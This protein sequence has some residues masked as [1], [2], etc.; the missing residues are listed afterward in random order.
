[1]TTTPA[2]DS[3][4]TSAPRERT[5]E[6]GR[7]VFHRS[8]SFG[9]VQGIEIGANWSWFLVFGLIVWSLAAAV[10]PDARPGLG[11][12][13]YVA[14][15]GVGAV[16]FFTSLVLHEL[17]H[18]VVAKREG[19]EIAGITLW[20]FGGVA[21]FKG[22]FPSAWAE[23][24]IA[25]AGPLVSVAI[26]LSCLA[27]GEYAGLPAEADAVVDWLGAINLVLVAFNMLPALPLDGGRVLRSLL[28]EAMGDFTRATRYAGALGRAFGQAMIFGG[29]V[30]LL[31]GGAAGGLWLALIG[32]F[33]TI[34]AAA[35]LSLATIRGAF[36]GLYVRDALVRD[37]ACVPATQTLREFV[38][39]S[40]PLSRHAAYPVVENGNVVG[41][42]P[43]ARVTG[44]PAASWPATRVRDAMLPMADA[45][46][47]DAD[48]ELAEAAMDLSEGIG[49]A[50]VTRQGSVVGMISITDVSR[51]LELRRLGG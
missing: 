2:H 24:R 21:Q 49:R 26:G 39:E 33:L 3:Q 15:A 51:M 48:D 12:G 38:D 19:M 13:A 40:F 47:L 22:M 5:D 10:F 1:M 45:P 50:L 28:W 16:L 6:R 29:A 8:V 17:G 34:A 4:P 27:V 31:F 43:F 20:V 11:D 23:F 46:T 25:I 7:G 37:P 36:E 14:M 44:V 9:R 41:L 42:L 18:A 35:E 30:L 32:W